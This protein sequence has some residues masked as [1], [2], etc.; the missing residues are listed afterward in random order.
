MVPPAQV[1]LLVEKDVGPVGHIQPCGEVDPGPEEAADEGGGE[2]VGLVHPWLHPHRLGHLPPQPPVGEGSPQQAGPAPGG[3]DD[4][5]H[6]RPAGGLGLGYLARG[7]GRRGRGG[8]RPALSRG[9]GRR[10]GVRDGGLVRGRGKNPLH[11]G[12]T[13][14]PL[15]HQTHRQGQAGRQDHPQQHHPP[16]GTGDPPGDLFQRQA[17]D[18]HH[19]GHHRGGGG[20]GQ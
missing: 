19:K 4:R 3:P 11:I 1:G 18:H 14:D 9:D 15:G 12:P 20:H 7:G 2:L 16:Q 17:E 6:G 5:D 8:L 13:G 10:R